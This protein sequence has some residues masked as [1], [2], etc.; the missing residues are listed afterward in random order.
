MRKLLLLA[1]LLCKCSA[2]SNFTV[3]LDQ[4]YHI[5]RRNYIADNV[6]ALATRS[7]NY[8]YDDVDG[9][10][11]HSLIDDRR[12]WRKKVLLGP[13]ELD[14][15]DYDPRKRH[16]YDPPRYFDEPEPKLFGGIERHREADLANYRKRYEDIEK[17]AALKS[18]EI[19][20]PSA[21]M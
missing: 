2:Y 21:Y 20:H 15:K 18:G 8:D 13:G 7:N 3:D 11:R 14:H 1:L 5:N 6:V 4:Q 17:L 10:K 12:N 16:D 9:S 19:A